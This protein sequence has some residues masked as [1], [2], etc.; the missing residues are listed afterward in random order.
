V[1]K[2]YRNCSNDSVKKQQKNTKSFFFLLFSYTYIKLVE[3]ETG[4]PGG[5]DGYT[6][7]RRQES[8]RPQGLGKKTKYY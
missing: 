7:K 3:A 5:L 4:N 2:Y 6:I 8:R 1:K